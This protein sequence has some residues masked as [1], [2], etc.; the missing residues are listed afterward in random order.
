MSTVRTIR[1]ST[2]PF[3]W[4]PGDPDEQL[5]IVRSYRLNRVREQLRLQ[6]CPAILLYDPVNIRYATDSSNM[7]I[8]TGRNPTRYILVFADGPVVAF[9]FHNCE[10]VW[11]GIDCVSEI[12]GA[13]CW[14]YFN[15][16]PE[17][18]RRAAQWADEIVDLLRREGTELCVAADRL[19]PEGVYALQKLGVR[20]V[21][22]QALIEQ[23]RC[24][25][26]PEE[27]AVMQRAIDVCE[28]GIARMH[29]A[30]VPGITEQELW[31]HLHFENIRYG[32]EWIETRLLSSGERTNPWMQECSSKVLEAGELLAF[33]TDLVGPYGYCADIS[34]TWTVGH[35]KPS[36]EQ[37]RLYATAHEQLHFNLDLVRAGMSFREFSQRSWK[38]PARYARN[39]YSCVA[40]GI[41]LVDEYPSIAHYSDW[42]GGGY[43]GLFQVGMAL[44]IESYIGDEDGREGVKLE[45]QVLLTE[46]GCVPLSTFP[47]ERSWL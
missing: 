14:N 30:L 8:W 11:R 24:V 7:Q 45:Q 41:G 21:D 27:I 16:G 1:A 39:R 10:H 17:S 36:D 43:D 42:E 35:V 6:G 23:A 9:E 40:H 22:G 20:I 4:R 37:R 32:G 31:A 12:R 15:A 25:K 26:S 34:R 38:I 5:D 28:R 29:D 46:S 13:T 3:A 18:A 47:F 19:D 33:D 44:C 2:E